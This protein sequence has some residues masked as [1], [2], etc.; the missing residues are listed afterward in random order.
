MFFLSTNNNEINVEN[1]NV[2]LAQQ[3]LEEGYPVITFWCDRIY[4]K[5]QHSLKNF[6]SN[7]YH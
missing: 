1:F 2:E 5:L 7:N 3:K 6:Q 4:E